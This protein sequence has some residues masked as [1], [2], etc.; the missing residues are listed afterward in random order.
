MKIKCYAYIVIEVIISEIQYTYMRKSFAVDHLLSCIEVTK[1]RWEQGFHVGGALLPCV[2][3]EGVV[4]PAVAW[5]LGSKE[6]INF[7]EWNL[8]YYLIV[9][10]FM[11]ILILEIQL[12]LGCCFIFWVKYFS[13]E[14][15]YL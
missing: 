7:G 10:E 15:L 2:S 8:Y 1:V 3:D 4:W 9:R 5:Y 6:V 14:L 12:V 11:Q 13:Q